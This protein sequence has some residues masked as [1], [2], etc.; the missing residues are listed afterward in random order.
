MHRDVR[1]CAAEARAAF[2]ACASEETEEEQTREGASG[3][4]HGFCA[5]RCQAAFADLG[6]SEPG[7][8]LAD[9]VPSGFSP[10]VFVF[11]GF[12]FACLL[13]HKNLG[14]AHL[15]YFCLLLRLNGT[16]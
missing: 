12:F 3:K 14:F 15:A 11:L 1:F 10:W 6:W 9:S 7:E 2:H 8:N 4:V 5:G 13:V 16:L